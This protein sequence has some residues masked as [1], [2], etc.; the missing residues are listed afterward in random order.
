MVKV[1]VNKQEIPMEIDTGASLSIVSEETLNI[2]S[3]GLDLKPTDVSL[4]MY[5]GEPLLVIGMLD[6]EVTYGP[7]Q[8]TLSL[9]VVQ[10]KGPSLFG[11]T[12]RISEERKHEILQR[13][14][15]MA[16]CHMCTK[17]CMLSLIGKLSF[18]L[19]SGNSW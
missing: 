5:T 18:A 6:V 13:L 4:R 11:R 10:G 15:H 2:F 9:I 12:A 7:Q 8:A 14:R 1:Q 16:K 3:S 17:R 19:Q